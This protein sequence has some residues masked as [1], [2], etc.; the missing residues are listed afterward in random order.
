MD[1]FILDSDKIS[2]LTIYSYLP[3][4][5]SI[6]I[7][8]QSRGFYLKSTGLYDISFKPI[9][10]V[11]KRHENERFLQTHASGIKGA[12]NQEVKVTGC[13]YPAIIR[14]PS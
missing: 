14:S 13:I 9:K 12:K 5:T 11:H 1:L 3:S 7:H 8:V 10:F 2:H 4:E 6:I